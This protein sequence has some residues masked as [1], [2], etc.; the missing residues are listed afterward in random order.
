[1]QEMSKR[2]RSIVSCVNLVR[3]IIICVKVFTEIAFPSVLR[4]DFC[5]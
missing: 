4:H 2:V 3:E 5:D 1:M